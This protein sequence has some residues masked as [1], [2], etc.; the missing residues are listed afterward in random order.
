[1]IGYLR[2]KIH[3]SKPTQIILD[4]NGVGYQVNI[5]VATF[6]EVSGKPE[7][8]LF[9][10]T[11]VREDA[12][13][14]FGFSTETEKQMFELLISI[15]GI[16]PKLALG[17]LSGIRVSD[18]KN[19]ILKNDVPRI[20]AVPGIGK[21]TAERLVLELRGKLD[22]LTV[23]TGEANYTVRSEATSALVSL[24]YNQ[25]TAEKVVGDLLDM[26]PQISLELLLTQA[27][28]SMGK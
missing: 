19:A 8:E 11:N 24:G 28:K 13:Q 20:T 4:V 15:T 21:K 27:L 10:Y 6:E 1:M 16:G 17:V 23:A 7:V 22:N 2:G 18:L 5:S 26:S 25:K 12:I 3:S 9:I 14:L